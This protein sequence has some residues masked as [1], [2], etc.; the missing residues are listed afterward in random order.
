MHLLEPEREPIPEFLTYAGLIRHNGESEPQYQLYLPVFDITVRGTSIY[1]V[2]EQGRELLGV[3]LIEK[4]LDGDE[5]PAQAT[6]TPIAAIDEMPTFI[7]VEI[8]RY[9]HL[10]KPKETRIFPVQALR[11]PEAFL[12]QVFDLQP[13]F[14]TEHGRGA[15]VIVSMRDF[16]MYQN[17]VGMVLDKSKMD[18]TMAD[19]NLE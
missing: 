19:L 17:A 8:S 4:V 11:Q 2:I 15:Y 6:M 10:I 18:D 5:L 1:E 12:S 13:V 14:I 9:K 16:D 7:N 3:M